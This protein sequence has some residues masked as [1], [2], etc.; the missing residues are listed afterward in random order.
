[1]KIRKINLKKDLDYIMST[2]EDL[3]Y[4]N[5]EYKL[6]RDDIES[7]RRDIIAHSKS[8]NYLILIAE[9]KNKQGGYIIV[10]FKE[11]LKN[12]KVLIIEELFTNK[13][14]RGKGIARRLL[15][16]I[17]VIAKKKNYKRIELVTSPTNKSAIHLYKKARFKRKIA[18]IEFSK[19]LK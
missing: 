17:E 10:Q 9:E 4:P 1:M 12:K 18:S 14:N 6:T 11:S 5:M 16:E 7:F 13:E 8:K 3:F 15:K 2:Q 19:N